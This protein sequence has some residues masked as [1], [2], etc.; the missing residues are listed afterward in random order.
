MERK[1]QAREEAVKWSNTFKCENYTYGDL[2]VHEEYFYRLAKRYG[3][4]RE[5]RE[6]GIQV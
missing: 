1:E 5:F 4:V 6:N 2:V 3:L